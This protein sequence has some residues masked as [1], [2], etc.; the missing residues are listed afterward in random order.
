MH[1]RIFCITSLTTA[2][3]AK[4]ASIS[5]AMLPL[6]GPL[7]ARRLQLRHAASGATFS[8]IYHNGLRADPGALAELSEVLA[9]TR[10]GE[11]RSFDVAALDI[12]WEMGRRQ[13]MA[14]LIVL[15]GYRTVATN[16]EVNGAV[17]SQ[18]LR[19]AALDLQIPKAR[20][21]SFGEEA[22]ELGRGGVGLYPTHGFI[23]LD[24]G[25]VRHWTDNGE[26]TPTAPMARR[27][28]PRTAAEQR[29]DRIAEAWA[30][31]RQR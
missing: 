10:T 9:D 31:S 4:P 24:S 30:N 3:F 12:A 28:P 11:T 16:R 14:E 6:P 8:G 26:P 22:I 18:H 27:P 1:R 19:A 15:S 20:F 29:I 5:A 21:G 23:H 25:P 7:N 17:N 13:R 2:V